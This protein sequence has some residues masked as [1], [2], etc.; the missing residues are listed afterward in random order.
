MDRNNFKLEDSLYRENN[1]CDGKKKEGHR[2]CI[3]Y[4]KNVDLY[5]VHIP[6]QFQNI[7]YA[8]FDE[9]QLNHYINLSSKLRN[10]NNY[11]QKDDTILLNL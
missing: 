9:V 10:K 6:I 2:K 7:Y 8:S 5:C 4:S 3:V 1:G 11:T